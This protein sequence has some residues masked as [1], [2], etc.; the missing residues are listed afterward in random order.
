MP[1]NLPEARR[2]DPNDRQSDFAMMIPCS[3]S[4]FGEFIASLLGRPQ[5]IEKEFLGGFKLSRPDVENLFYLIKQRV[6][7]QNDAQLIQFTIK[8][9]YDDYSNVELSTFDDF[10]TYAEIKSRIPHR[11]QMSW[12]FLIKFNDRPAP[13]KQVI[14][15]DFNSGKLL[16][17]KP[18]F[19]LKIHHT[20]RSWG[21]DIESLVGG[22]ISTLKRSEPSPLRKRLGKVAPL[23]GLFIFTLLMVLLLIGL[24]I[25]AKHFA[26]SQLTAFSTN[27]ASVTPPEKMEKAVFYLANS[28]LSGTLPKYF[29]AILLYLIT[30]I[31]LSIVITSAATKSLE[32]K[33]RGFLLLNQCAEDEYD[34]HLAKMSGLKYGWMVGAISS[35]IVGLASNALFQWLCRFI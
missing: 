11:F 29:I 17:I 24:S 16:T 10:Q 34:E 3:Q 13:E 21:V 31:F 25:A 6:E 5:T 30:M 27:M 26:D 8:L 7:Q 22:H 18:G 4:A 9:N 28:V 15:L 19:S 23:I 35:L 20:G 2:M 12:T 32:V 1:T 33:I 14:E